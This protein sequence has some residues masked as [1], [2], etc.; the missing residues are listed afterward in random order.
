MGVSILS[1]EQIEEL[2]NN[3]YVASVTARQVRLYH[4]IQAALLR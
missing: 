4:R 1:L 2:K 3:P